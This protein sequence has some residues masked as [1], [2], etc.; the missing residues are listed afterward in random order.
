MPCGRKPKHRLFMALI[1]LLV[2]APA[3]AQSV[4]AGPATPDRPPT[5]AVVTSDDTT[6]AENPPASSESVR[7]DL[8]ELLVLEIGNQRFLQLV[9]RQSLAAVLKEHA[10]ALASLGDAKNA[11]VLGK[12]AGAD[13]LL[14]VVAEGKVATVHLVEV[15]SG[16]VKLAEKMPI[17][18]DRALFAAAVREKVLAVLRPDARARDRLTVGITEFPNRSGN[19]LSDPFAAEVQKALRRRLEEQPWA[20]VLERQYPTELLSEVDLARVGLVRGK[21]SE[22][23]PPADLVIM[24]SLDD[25]GRQYE[26]GKPWPVLITLTMR[27]RGQV[28]TVTSKCRSDAVEAAAADLLPP[29]DAFRRRQPQAHPDMP[30]KEL[31]RRHALY[32]MPR[33]CETWCRA[34]VPNFFASSRLNKLETVRAWEN[35]LLLDPDDAEAMTYLGVCLVGFNRSSDPASAARCVE[36]TRWVERALRTHF[37]QERADTFI[38][39]L[40]FLQNFALA[41]AHEMAL[42]ISG[43]RELFT[44]A[45][46]YWV[47]QALNTPVPEGGN[48][49]D[50][51]R[52]MWQRAVDNAQ[53]DPDS[54][55]LA[56]SHRPGDRRLPLDQMADFLAPYADAPDAVVQFMAQRALGQVLA[57]EKGDPKGLQ[58]FDRAIAVLDQACSRCI[59]PGTRLDD[60]YR[61][62]MDACLRLGRGEE[63]QATALAGARHFIAVGRYDDSVAWLYHHCVMEILKPA[64]DPQALVICEAFLKGF[65]KSYWTTGRDLRPAVA[66]KRWEILARR[67]GKPLPEMSGV[68]LVPGTDQSSRLRMAAAGKK[69]WLVLY[70]NSLPRRAVVYRP[71]ADEISPLLQVPYAISSV[72]AMDD[73]VWFGGYEGLYKLDTEGRL[74][75]HYDPQ[76]S[77]MP[78]RDV[79]EVCVGGGKVYF[80]FQGSPHRG[81]A[82]LDPAG[83]KITVLARAIAPKWVIW[84]E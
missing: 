72:A 71:D 39:C 6:A 70:V 28:E 53:Q 48:P 13:Y 20:V 3:G 68:R 14:Y 77:A 46:N 40:H 54:V 35:V 24:G 31:W 60:I 76:D 84:Y 82:V 64:D 61:M 41:R 47:K 2:A 1:A 50:G 83:E 81:V 34:I 69:L 67:A 33:R 73:S 44:H 18:A 63:A 15:A 29:I 62:R 49:R 45:D 55:V 43:H 16:Q 12:F 56:F 22:T 42:Y 7:R 4:P 27:L 11:I 9:D 17:A 10:I 58:H 8:E 30:E 25:A 36:G 66:A 21:G 80:V 37:S 74:L 5:L 78:G 32:L 23:L 19:Q 26:P 51:V 79:D 38:A 65:E 57:G 52:A 59:Y 75:K